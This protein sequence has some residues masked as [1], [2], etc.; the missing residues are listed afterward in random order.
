MGNVNLRHI[1]IRVSRCLEVLIGDILILL[2]SLLGVSAEPCRFPMQDH[3]LHSHHLSA[4]ISPPLAVLAF[5]GDLRLALFTTW[6][7]WKSGSLQLEMSRC[8]RTKTWLHTHCSGLCFPAVCTSLVLLFLPT[9]RGQKQFKIQLFQYFMSFWPE[10][11]LYAYNR[12][13]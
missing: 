3:F 1:Y 4:L 11:F 12:T 5:H 6:A 8:P 2:A 13:E 10:G 7:H 9:Q